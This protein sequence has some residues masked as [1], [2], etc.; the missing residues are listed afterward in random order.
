MV[1]TPSAL[2]RPLYYR[3][4]NSVPAEFGSEGTPPPDTLLSHNLLGEKSKEKLSPRFTCK[5]AYLARTHSR[6]TKKHR[7][8]V[9]ALFS[10]ELQEYTVCVCSQQVSTDMKEWHLQH[11]LDSCSSTNGIFS[12]PHSANLQPRGRSCCGLEAEAAQCVHVHSHNSSTFPH[13]RDSTKL[14]APKWL[15]LKLPC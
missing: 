15:H 7:C 8:V 5:A 2:Q 11:C 13:Q 6:N 14:N 1:R 9:A 12:P 3:A 4:C 10:S